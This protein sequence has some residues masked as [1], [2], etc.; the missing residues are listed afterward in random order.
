MEFKT[1]TTTKG[2]D[3]EI[4]SATAKVEDPVVRH[5]DLV[6]EGHDCGCSC[7][8]T[9]SGCGGECHCHEQSGL[10]VNKDTVGVQIYRNRSD[11]EAVVVNKDTGEFI[12]RIPVEWRHTE[13]QLDYLSV[14]KM[15][16]YEQCPSCFYQQYMDA[17]GKNVDNSNFF[18]KFG[19]I[20]HEVVERAFNYYENSGIIVD[21]M[22]IFD[23]VWKEHELQG[24][25]A[26]L[27]GK[28]LIKDY[29]KRAPIDKRDDTPLLQEYE[30]RGELGGVEFGLQIDYVGELKA[31][32]T[33]GVLKDYKTNRQAFT[34]TQLESSLQLRIYEL[35][36]RRH[37]FPEY[38]KWIA[39]YEM[40]RFGWQPCPE[41]TMDDLLDAEAYVENVASQI[42]HDNTW[43]PRLNNFCGF[44]K[45]RLTCP[46]YADYI[47]NTQKYFDIIP[48]TE[49]S[50][51]DIERNR[52]QMA[53]YEKI[54]KTRKDECASILLSEI[55][56]AA[57][58]GR[59]VI[60]NGNELSIQCQAKSGYRY[61]DVRNVLLA[62][63]KLD[64]LDDCLSISKT[65]FDKVAKTMDPET[66]MAL[67]QCMTQN[68]SS[69]YI[70]TKKVTT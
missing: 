6:P 20:L 52:E 35:V 56:R 65:K 25:D 12:E 44:R 18:T 49:K 5:Q 13:N 36:L 41:W 67:A 66:R 43:E 60:A 29:F 27:E 4:T 9:C 33:V 70:T 8:G 2:A 58:E 69:G 53:A 39:G 3:N 19:S 15:Q 47:Q 62:R 31:D 63:G 46:L 48:T 11:M 22:S 61:Y 32:P 30:W 55:E 10:T 37:I 14:S 1:I 40:F 54:A 26:Y 23:D 38:K 28:Q 34:P 68:Y 64:V 50:I 51:D 45:C 57:C 59:K 16:A 42:R 17:D 7:G 24:F 21:P